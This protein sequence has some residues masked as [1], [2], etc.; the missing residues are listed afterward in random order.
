MT[1]AMSTEEPAMKMEL[2]KKT[3]KLVSTAAWPFM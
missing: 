3:S 1:R 2:K